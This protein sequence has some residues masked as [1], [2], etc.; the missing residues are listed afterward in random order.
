MNAGK[1]V[2]AY[3]NP[4]RS[5]DPIFVKG[6]DLPY[7]AEIISLT[8]I[9]VWTNI[10]IDTQEYAI[11]TLNLPAGLYFLLITDNVARKKVIRLIIE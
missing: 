4:V 10:K 3:P 5:G 8:G 11:P 7:S 1:E 6:N 2:V 9:S